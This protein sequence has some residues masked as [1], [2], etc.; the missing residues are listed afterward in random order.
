MVEQLREFKVTVYMDSNK[1]TKRRVFDW[2]DYDSI[3][4]LLDAATTFLKRIKNEGVLE[5]M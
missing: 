5:V 2:E 3:G 1:E 4:E